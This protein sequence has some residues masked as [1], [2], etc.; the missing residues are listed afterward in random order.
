MRFQ[1][2]STEEAERKPGGEE[3]RSS[4]LE[5]VLSRLTERPPEHR[6]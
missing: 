5:R 2:A 3:T 4:A 1:V 6:P